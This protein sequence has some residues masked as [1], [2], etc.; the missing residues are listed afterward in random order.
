MIEKEHEELTD[1]LKKLNVTEINLI[2]AKEQLEEEIKEN[3]AGLEKTMAEVLETLGEIIREKID[4]SQIKY[5]EEALCGNSLEDIVLMCK[6]VGQVIFF[7]QAV[8]VYKTLKKEGV[9]TEI[10]KIFL[11]GLRYAHHNFMY[12]IPK[13]G[14]EKLKEMLKYK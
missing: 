12:F 6:E 3:K 10:I 7:P 5:V 9:K 2:K 14:E 1:K 13:K 4:S 11:E 8:V